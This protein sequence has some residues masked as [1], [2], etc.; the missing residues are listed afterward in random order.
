MSSTEPQPADK[1]GDGPCL[2]ELI[3]RRY[4]DRL[5]EDQA[6]DLDNIVTGITGM[7]ARLRSVGLA[8][9][10]EPF[11]RFVPYREDD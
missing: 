9:S 5:T 2:T 3:R 7:A 8:N 4:G 6:A 11:T 10:D 1:S